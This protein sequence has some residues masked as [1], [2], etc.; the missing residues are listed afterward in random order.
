MMFAHLRQVRAPTCRVAVEQLLLQRHRFD[1]VLRC[2][3]LEICLLHD[4]QSARKLQIC[5]GLAAHV[6]YTLR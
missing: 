4:A 5:A 2:S 3:S 6:T 1:S